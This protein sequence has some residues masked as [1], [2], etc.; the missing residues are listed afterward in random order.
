MK[1]LFFISL[2]SILIASCK[3]ITKIY[4]GVKNPSFKT[5]KQLNDFLVKK[6]LNQSS[7]YYIKS[8]KN[9]EKLL[10]EK[11]SSFPEAYFFNKDGDFVNYK[12]DSRECNANVGEFIKNLTEFSNF[13]T[14]KT[15]NIKIFEDNICNNKNEKFKAS[16]INVIITWATFVGKVNKNKAFEWIELIEEAKRKGININYYLVNYDLQESWKL[17]DNEKKGILDAFK[18]Q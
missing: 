11:Y 9:Y 2:L 14:V 13:K 15:K 1:K 6:D 10:N 18:I 8:W 3:T 16:D 17:S 12:K 7:I 5:H 4:L